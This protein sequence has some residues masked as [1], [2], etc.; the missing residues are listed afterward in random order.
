MLAAVGAGWTRTEIGAVLGMKYQAVA[1]RVATART[2]YGDATP[3]LLGDTPLDRPP[4]PAAVLCRPVEQREWLTVNEAA[5]L[6]GCHILTVRNWRLGG[7]LPNTQHPSSKITCT[8][9]LI[10]NA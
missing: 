2:R 10:C 5:Q 1:A 7:L 9:A 3:A 6:A 4:N 8:S